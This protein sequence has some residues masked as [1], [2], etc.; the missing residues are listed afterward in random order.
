[1]ERLLGNVVSWILQN[2]IDEWD[3]ANDTSR[4]LTEY[5]ARDNFSPRDLSAR[6]QFSPSERPK[7]EGSYEPRV[8]S[9]GADIP[10]PAPEPPTEA[11]SEPPAQ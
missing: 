6:D 4:G 7:F 9:R 5:N 10:R 8:I 3:K 1:V 2:Q 11:I